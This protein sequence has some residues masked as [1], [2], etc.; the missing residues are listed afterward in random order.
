MTTLTFRRHDG[1]SLDLDVP[2]APGITLL[3]GAPGTRKTRTLDALA[4]RGR[5]TFEVENYFTRTGDA[6]ERLTIPN[7]KA[8]SRYLRAA[9]DRTLIERISAGLDTNVLGILWDPLRLVCAYQNA[10]RDRLLSTGEEAWVAWC[11]FIHRARKRAFPLVLVDTPETFFPEDMQTMAFYDLAALAETATIVV[12]T[13][14][15]RVA[16][17]TLPHAVLLKTLTLREDAAGTVRVFRWG[18]DAAHWAKHTAVDP[19]GDLYAGGMLNP[20]LREVPFLG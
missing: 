4:M 18:E 16:L 19:P 3:I 1:F 9:S 10:T 14:A 13:H 20:F 2:A 6:H 7:V 5:T 12:A 8:V 11:A 15:V 17:N